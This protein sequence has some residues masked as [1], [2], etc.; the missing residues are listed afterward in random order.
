MKD[1]EQKSPATAIAEQVKKDSKPFSLSYNGSGEK[2]TTNRPKKTAPY[3]MAIRGD[4]GM[5]LLQANPNAFI[6]LYVIANRAQR[7]DKFNRYHLKPGE[8]LLGDYRVC[9][10]TQQKYRTA[11]HDLERWGFAKFRT[12]NKGTIATLLDSSVFDVNIRIGNEQD[13]E[14]G[15]EQITDGQRTDNEQITTTK[16]GNNEKNEKNGKNGGM[17][18]VQQ[19]S[20]PWE[21]S[22]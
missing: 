17:G 13:N 4:D 5:E 12:T 9:G 16:N 1:I 19:S 7:T 15:N 22:E 11:K 20:L 8:A 14:L 2:S 6:L 21:D 10:L 3:F 18:E